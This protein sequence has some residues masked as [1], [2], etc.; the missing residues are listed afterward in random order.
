MAVGYSQGL[1]EAVKTEE[2]RL[3]VLLSSLAAAQSPRGS[4]VTIHPRTIDKVL[5]ELATH[6]DVARRRR[7]PCCGLCRVSSSSP[8]LTGDCESAAG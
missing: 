2:Q 7:G 1:V 5:Q 6:G 3:A 8:R 4:K